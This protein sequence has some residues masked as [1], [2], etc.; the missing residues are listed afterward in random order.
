MMFRRSLVFWMGFCVLAFLIWAW[1]FSF[2]GGTYVPFGLLGDGY[3]VE[4]GCGRI[5][6]RRFPG[7]ASTFQSFRGYTS[8]AG[9]DAWHWDLPRVENTGHYMGLLLPHWLVTVCFVPPWLGGSV[10]HAR[11]IG[12]LREAMVHGG[13]DRDS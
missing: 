10:W 1:V 11:R 13:T 3:E 6:I 12:K 2:V 7:W 9:C 4:H 5:M 8:P